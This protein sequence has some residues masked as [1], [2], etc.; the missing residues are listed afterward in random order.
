MSAREPL[1]TM[2]R[3]S[4]N[5]DAFC[6]VTGQEII[7]AGGQALIA[8]EILCILVANGVKKLWLPF[9]NLPFSIQCKKAGIEDQIIPDECDALYFGTPTIV[10]GKKLFENSAPG[11]W[12][13]ERE[14]STVRDMC[15]YAS[16]I[17]TFRVIVSGLGSGDVT[18]SDRMQD[19]N[20]PGWAYPQVAAFKD[21]GHF[22]DWV[23][24]TARF[25]QPGESR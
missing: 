12:N 19:M 3:A 10:D 2:H 15:A 5:D 9:P 11:H 23:I 24:A 8:A 1:A 6:R 17:P 16:S 4:L 25:P 21:F 20:L 13:A 14:R 18:W 22:K 7:E